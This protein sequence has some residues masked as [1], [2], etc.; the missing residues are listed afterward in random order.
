MDTS[1]IEPEHMRPDP[2][3]RNGFFAA[4]SISPEA[5]AY[6]IAQFSKAERD[7]MQVPQVDDLPGWRQYN[8]TALRERIPENEKLLRRYSPVLRELILNGVEVLDIRPPDWREDRK[9]VLYTH[10]GGYV[11]GTAADAMD[12]TLP[13][14]IE[15]GLRVLSINYTLAPHAKFREVTDEPVRVIEALL[16]AGHTMSDIAMYGDSAG[17]GLA[18]AVA[19]KA[20]DRGLGL[21]AALV[22]W[23]P[24]VDLT[25]SG[26]TCTTLAH[27]EPFYRT[28]ALLAT[29]AAAYAEE[30]DRRHPYASPLFADFS[31]GYPATLI[32]VGTRELLLSDS[33]RLFQALETAGQSAKLDVYE[34]MWHVFQFKP[35]DIPEAR[36]ARL[37]TAAYLKRHLYGEQI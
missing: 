31:A 2:Q 24:W 28:D 12:S 3:H 26:E 27:E 15:S 1:S 21:L 7:R 16:H 10:G 20:R 17:A 9:I 22:L 36:N 6:F 23:S 14:A 8:D 33:V 32:Q 34:G 5:R 35:I 25:L 30:K 13:L 11:G 37:K 19:L 29:A 4:T 18:A